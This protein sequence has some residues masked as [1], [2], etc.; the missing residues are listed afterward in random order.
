MA[1]VVCTKAM[2]T[3]LYAAVQ[4]LDRNSWE[5]MPYTSLEGC[6]FGQLSA[7]RGALADLRNLYIDCG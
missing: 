4:L 2:S 3:S 5:Y 7:L 6:L 1:A